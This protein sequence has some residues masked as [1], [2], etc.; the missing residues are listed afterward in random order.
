MKDVNDLLDNR[1]ERLEAPFSREWIVDFSSLMGFIQTNAFTQQVLDEIKKE[2]TQAHDLLI[3][4]LKSLFDDGK[5]CLKDI[6]ARLEIKNEIHDQVRNL[7]KFK[8]NARDVENPFFELESLYYDYCKGFDSLFRSLAKDHADAFISDYCTLT[9]KKL[10]GTDHFIIHLSFSP[11]LQKCKQNIEILSGERATSTWGK[12]DVLVKWAEWTKNGISPSNH[13]FERNLQNLFSGMKIASAVQT[14]GLFFLER[15][16]DKPTVTADTEACLKAVE[17]YVDEKNQYWIILHF[18][19]ENRDR[20]E[21]FIT[22]LQQEARSYELLMLLLKSDPYSKIEFSNLAHTLG[23]L[24]IKK[25]LKKLFFPND[26]FAGMFVRLS[27]MDREID[28]DAIIKHLQSTVAKK[29]NIPS[30]NSWEYCRHHSSLSAL[31]NI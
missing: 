1:L 15:L 16:A 18:S 26:K 6:E 2:K 13:A 28:V 7:L 20:R 17:L 27:E 3:K 14:C 31:S 29:K 5:K 11:Y 23:E 24:E 10:Q 4:N 30:F 21:F 22:K 25:E 9:H 12:W 8:V 19:G